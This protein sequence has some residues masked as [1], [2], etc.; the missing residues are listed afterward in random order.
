MRSFR[1]RNPYAVGLVSLLIIGAITGFAFM[2]GLLHLL[3][4]TYEM[5]GTFTDAAGLRSGDDV[6][7]AGVKVGRVTGIH[8]DRDEGLVRVEW[9]VN[10]GVDIREGAGADLALETLLGSKFVRITNA[11]TGEELM[12]D[13]PR[14]QR[15]I[16]Y[17]DCT[18]AANGEEEICE[19]RTRTAVDVFDLTREATE[20][21]EQTDNDRLNQLVNQLA[22]VTEGKRATVTDLI[23]GIGEVSAALTERE[24]ELEA[25]LDEADELGANLAAKDQTLVQLIDSSRTI[26]DF[27]VQRRDQL[28]T[29][30]GEGSAAVKALSRLI[31]DNRAQLDAILSDL[32]PTLRTVD[33]NLPDLNSAL[34]I[35]GPAFYGQ[36]L[37]GT[38]G[39]WQDIYVAALGPDLIGII[40]DVQGAAGL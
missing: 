1:D 31:S 15:A 38:H 29:A 4:D 40:E 25:L 26:L 17:Q 27:L 14:E 30:L 10:S 21:I 11:A 24:G 37:A 16:P 32:H 23:N 33:Q 18:P 35:A 5:E 9:V 19:Q 22:D 20:R 6:K 2:V 3:E 12:E 28:S 34:A 39:P 13:L 8:A 36:S 7:V